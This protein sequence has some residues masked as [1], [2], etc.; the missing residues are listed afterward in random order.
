M[1]RPSSVNLK[2]EIMLINDYIASVVNL[3]TNRI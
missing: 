2:V 1:T 3:I